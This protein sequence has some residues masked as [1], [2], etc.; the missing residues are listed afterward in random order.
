MQG[1]TAER[2]GKLGQPLSRANE[3]CALRT[4]SGV[5]AI[6]VSRFTASLEDD[7][8]LLSGEGASTSAAAGGSDGAQGSGAPAAAEPLTPDMRMSVQFR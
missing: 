2:L 8:R 1:R 3:T 6:A 7:E 4:L 5:A